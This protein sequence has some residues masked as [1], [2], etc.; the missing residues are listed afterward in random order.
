M[1]TLDIMPQTQRPPVRPLRPAYVEF[2]GLPFSLLSQAEVV[3]LVMDRCGAPYRYVVTPNAYHVATVHDQPERLLPV[4]RDAWLSLCD[5]RIIRALARLR[6]QTLPLVTGSDLV[7]A[8]LAAL[9]DRRVSPRKLLIIGPPRSSESILRAVYPQLAFE[10]MPA[11]AGLAQSAELRHAVATGCLERSWDIALLCVGCPAQE[12][13]ARELGELGR[14]AGI[15]LCVGAAVDFL[16][17]AS[18][19]APRWLQTLNL[20][21]AYRLACEPLRLWRRYLVESPKILRVFLATRATDA[22]RRS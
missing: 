15:A 12:L 9:N 3:R 2:L 13:I 5:S 22:G 19:R 11:P 17:G 6:R 8:L 1:T 21:W 4:Y 20:E 10:V 7:P 16:T 14:S 18:S